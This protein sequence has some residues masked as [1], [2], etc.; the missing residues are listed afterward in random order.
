MTLT[1]KGRR[2]LDATIAS[3]AVILSALLVLG[4]YVVGQNWKTER[5]THCVHGKA[6]WTCP[7]G[8]TP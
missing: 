5:L 6:G 7:E 2:W 1:P 3:A 4:A 8:T